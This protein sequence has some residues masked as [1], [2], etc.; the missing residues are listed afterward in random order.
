MTLELDADGRSADDPDYE[1][2]C[3]VTGLCEPFE[4]EQD[5]DQA[6]CR[7]CGGWRRRD[8]PRPG[9]WGIPEN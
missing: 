2:P 7:F 4:E 6:M 5:R 8:Y 3:D 9:N 1:P